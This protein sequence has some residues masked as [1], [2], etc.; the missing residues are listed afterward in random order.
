MWQELLRYLT[1][2]VSGCREE[3]EEETVVLHL[4]P[5]LSSPFYLSRFHVRCEPRYLSV[6]SDLV[7]VKMV[8]LFLTNQ[9]S[10]NFIIAL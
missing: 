6:F 3:E 2:R 9:D 8:P 1:Y 5:A 10:H 7:L 4:S